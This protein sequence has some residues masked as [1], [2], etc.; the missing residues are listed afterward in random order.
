MS[1]VTLAGFSRNL[2][3]IDM[4]PPKDNGYDFLCTRRLV[5]N[6][7]NPRFAKIGHAGGSYLTTSL[8]IVSPYQKPRNTYFGRLLPAT[9]LYSNKRHSM[10]PLYSGVRLEG[11]S[12]ISLAMRRSAVN[13]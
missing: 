7:T 10:A 8:R 1:S 3:L 2:F 4:V 5:V 6:K 13:R 11:V 12:R 9:I